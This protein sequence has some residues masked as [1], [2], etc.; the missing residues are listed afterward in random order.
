M[1][2]II[3]PSGVLSM[4]PFIVLVSQHLVNDERSTAIPPH[5]LQSNVSPE[6][7]A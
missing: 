7:A 3:K 1:M 4:S 2:V 5:V 6:N